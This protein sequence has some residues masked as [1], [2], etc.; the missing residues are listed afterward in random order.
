MVPPVN[1]RLARRRARTWSSLLIAVILGTAVIGAVGVLLV[2]A[3]KPSEPKA[4]IVFDRAPSVVAPQPSGT[5]SGSAVRQVHQAL[6]VLARNCPSGKPVH[7][8]NHGDRV[9]VAV[10]TILGFARDHPD[11]RFV[12]DDENGTT[13]ELLVVTREQ[14]RSC[15]P[16]LL[17]RVDRTLPPSYRTAG[18]RDP[19]LPGRTR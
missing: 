6:H 19:Q 12:I 3:V 9:G 8:T 4:A 18:P 11:A 14:L 16:S 7:Q 1:A 13:L 5:V 17:G 2:W 15:A 10:N